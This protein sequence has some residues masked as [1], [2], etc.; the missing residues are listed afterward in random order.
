MPS[1][2]DAKTTRPLAFDGLDLYYV[3]GTAVRRRRLPAGRPSTAS[4]PNDDFEQAIPIGSE[5]PARVV[6][7]I[8]YAGSQPGEPVHEDL[9]STVWFAFTPQ[10]SET[11]YIEFLDYGFAYNV[12]TGSSISTLTPL[13]EWS[14]G[15]AG[16]CAYAVPVEAGRTYFVSVGTSTPNY[17]TFVIKVNRTL[18][19][20][21]TVC[22]SPAPE[23]G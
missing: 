17:E 1:Q 23:A 20:G 13:L 16:E 5:L 15:T 12:F 4:A 18:D 22:G 19:R 7:R 8:G 11:V 2:A 21:L 9:D 6:S 10:Q 3:D 14:R